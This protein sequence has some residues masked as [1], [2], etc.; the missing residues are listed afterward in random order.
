MTCIG[1]LADIWDNNTVGLSFD[2]LHLSIAAPPVTPDL[3][4]LPRDVG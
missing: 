3:A 2:T 4:V 1:H